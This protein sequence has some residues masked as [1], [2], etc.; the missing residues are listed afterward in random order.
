MIAKTPEPNAWPIF[1]AG[2]ALL[3]AHVVRQRM[4]N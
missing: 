4:Q 3:M 1:V 2:L